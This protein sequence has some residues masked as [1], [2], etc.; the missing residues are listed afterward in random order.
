MR[1]P[2][3]WVTLISATRKSQG[4][5]ELED[6][7]NIHWTTTLLHLPGRRTNH[8][9]RILLLRNERGPPIANKGLL[10]R[11]RLKSDAFG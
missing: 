7:N 8:D 5:P 6:A 10:L 4:L 11:E 2:I 9:N 1:P 3:D